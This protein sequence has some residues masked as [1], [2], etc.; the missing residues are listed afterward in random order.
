MNRGTQWECGL[1]YGGDFVGTRPIDAEFLAQHAKTWVGRKA[2]FDLGGCRLP[3]PQ[4]VL[5]Q[6][7]PRQASE[8]RRLPPD[9]LLRLGRICGS[10]ST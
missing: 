7:T 9:R 6:T 1:A 3:S 5:A 4:S 8:G 2:E 10:E